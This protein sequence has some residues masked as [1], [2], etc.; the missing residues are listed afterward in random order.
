M[1]HPGSTTRRRTPWLPIAIAAL[2]LGGFATAHSGGGQALPSE[3]PS[4]RT[5]VA[6]AATAG[7]TRAEVRAALFA[8]RAQGRAT[9]AGEIGDTR[10]VLAARDRHRAQQAAD[11]EAERAVA[12]AAAEDALRARQEVA[13]TDD[14]RVITLAELFRMME[15]AA[16]DGSVLVVRVD[17]SR[18]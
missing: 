1:N 10:A 14:D 8:A 5:P 18:R 15:Q 12:V 16:D 13:R 7:T 2:T 6:P 9:P 11:L 17:D 3:L 4:L